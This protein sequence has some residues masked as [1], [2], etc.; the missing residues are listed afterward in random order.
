[1]SLRKDGR[2]IV[3]VTMKPEL[4]E[5]LIE[6]CRELDLPVTVFARNAIT[7]AL[8]SAL[9]THSERTPEAYWRIQEEAQRYAGLGGPTWNRDYIA[10]LAG[11]GL[12]VSP[13][14][15]TG[16]RDEWYPHD[17]PMLAPLPYHE[18][19]DQWPEGSLIVWNPVPEES[20]RAQPLDALTKQ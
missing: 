13:S 18:G 3:S 2:R 4:Y 1:M 16:D 17:C 12:T 19:G 11:W 7:A 5:Q 10:G 20:I 8:W 9:A 14:R 6:R 15:P